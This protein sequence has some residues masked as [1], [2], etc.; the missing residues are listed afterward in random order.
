MLFVGMHRVGV[1]TSQFIY[2]S[3]LRVCTSLKSLGRGIQTQGCRS[4]SNLFEWGGNINPVVSS[5]LQKGFSEI[6]NET[7]GKSLHAF[8]IKNFCRLSMF[9]TNTLINMYSKYGKLEAAWYVFDEMPQR[10]E[11]TWNTM[12]SAFVRF[13]L[14]PDAFLLFAQMRAQGFETSGFVIAKDELLGLQVLGHVIKCGFEYNLS[15]ANS[16]ISMFGN[17]GR[18]QEACYIFNQMSVRD[19][20]SWNAMISAYAHN[21]SYEYS[22]RCFNLMRHAREDLDAI[23]LSALLSACGSMDNLFWGAAVHGLV[24]KLGLDSN[25]CLC[26]TLL[27]MYS[28]AGRSKEM[29]QLFEEMPNKDLISWN[30]LIAGHVQEGDYLNALMVFVR[31]LQRQ[32]SVNHVTF[33]SALTACSDPE[34][35]GKAETLHA[36]VFTS[37]LHDNLIVG[38]ALVTMYGK[39]KMMR[40]AEE[41]FKRMSQKDLV[42]WNT[43]IGGYA[44]CEEPNL[45]IKAFNFMRKRDEPRNYITLVHMLSSCVAPNYLL[46]HGMGLHSHVIITGFDS[47][48]YVKNSL[49]TMYGK[50]NDLESSMQIFDGFVNKAYVSWN[51]MIA[52]YAHHGHGEEALKR[53]SEMNKTGNHLDHFSFSAALSAA[54]Y[55]SSLEE[56]QQLHGLTVKFG[57]DSNQYVMT[58][59]LDMYGKCGEINDMV[60]MLPEPKTRP[61]VLWNILISALARQGSFQEAKESF[62]EMVK[63]GS[64]PDHVTFV[65]LLS[66]CSHGGLVDEGL[67]YYSSMTTKFGVPVGIEHCVCIIDLLGRSGR[68]SEAESFIK[69]M[70]IPPNDFVWRSLLAACRIHG[71]SQLGKQAAEHLLESNPSDDSAYVL[72]SNV[73]ASSG[74]WEAVRNLREEMQF[75]NVKKKPACSWIKMKRKV[76]S[77]AIGDKSHPQNGKI[78]TKLDEIKKMIKEAGYV[79][80]TSFALQDIDE[81]QKED[82]LW[83]HSE[84]LALAYGLINSPEG[85]ILQI[86]KNLRVC[87]DC[88][89]VFKF[90]SSIARRKIIL[91][92]PFRPTTFTSKIQSYFDLGR[93]HDAVNLTLSHPVQFHHPPYVK[94]LQLC[95]DK[96]A[97]NQGHLVHE[98]LYANGFHSNLHI[99]TKLVILY[100]KAGDMKSARDVFDEM[101]ERSVVSWT[102]LLS[103]YAQNGS[104]KEALMVFRGMRQAG[105]KANQFTYASAL[106]ACK[107]LMSL[108]YGVQIQGCVHKGR[109]LDDL[110]VQCALVELHSKCGKMEDAYCIFNLMSGMTPDNFTLA[111]VL[112][113]CSCGKD[114]SNVRQLHGFVLKL[115]FESYYSLN[116]SLIN[117]YTKSGSII[118]ADKINKNM[119]VKD[120][121]CCTALIMGY[122]HEARGGEIEEAYHLI[123]DMH[124]KPNA[125]VW[126]AILGACSVYGNVAVGKVAARHLFDM[127]PG[128]SV[129]YVVL[130]SIYAA[131]GLWDSASDTRKLMK[132]MSMVLPGVVGFSLSG[133]LCNIITT[134]NLVLTVMQ[135]LREHGGVGTFGEFFSDVSTT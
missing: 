2:G 50:C 85:S 110:F 130:A 29:V 52:A 51:A 112:M 56:G 132:A 96:K 131:A 57:F 1:K 135:T 125:S 93:L 128:N 73:C 54:A 20:I 13:S 23:T 95:I 102:A 106:S 64:K 133:R 68:L 43:L 47:E 116:G 35:L 114:L 99:N 14:Y 78:Y 121:I 31:M 119:M 25:L 40:K 127:D 3:S 26:N 69:K 80:D 129:N 34:L 123:H 104:G 109:F 71:N 19:T 5:F 101:R 126:G 120:T 15:V 48:D 16:L 67:A 113:A 91:R 61:R 12:I 105:V 84:R 111:S 17:S 122:A 27:G 11:A 42:T 70:P 18:V 32:K 49:I 118:S 82:H 44:G 66:A 100:S 77:F 103:G 108:G 59:M 38:N 90:I 72:Y 21:H 98:H 62:H 45:A 117:A 86:F 134:T 46:S 94:L 65:S 6:T 115:G 4:Q 97:Y 28:E 7:V 63:M 76:S 87:G 36:L 37:G 60:K 10:N 58:A 81:E 74:K 89:S 33:A 53:F 75:T 79:P 107:S 92:D 24:H 22:F 8:C 83:K 124:M 41:I 9:H 30:S 39:H 88:H 55:L